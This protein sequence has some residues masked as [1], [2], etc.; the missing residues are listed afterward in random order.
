V[1][2]LFLFVLHWLN[3]FRIPLELERDELKRRMKAVRTQ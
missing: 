2:R 1:T 3:P